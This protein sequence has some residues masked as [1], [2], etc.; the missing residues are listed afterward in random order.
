MNNIRK[1][2]LI[3]LIFVQIILVGILYLKPEWLLNV[4]RFQLE[5]SN[6]ANNNANK[7]C[8][9]DGLFPTY[10]DAIFSGPD[11]MI[12]VFKGS[13]YWLYDSNFELQSNYPK[14]INEVWGS[15]IP[16]DI[17][18]VFEMDSKV[19]FIYADKVWK[20]DYF[21]KETL[22]GWERGILISS[23]WNGLPNNINGVYYYNY[24]ICCFKGDKIYR[25]VLDSQ[26]VSNNTK[27]FK[28]CPT[29]IDACFIYDGDYIEKSRSKLYVFRGDRYYRIN[30]DTQTKE[31]AH[32]DGI[33]ISIIKNPPNIIKTEF[34]FTNKPEIWKVPKTGI[35]R[36]V[37]YGASAGYGGKGSKMCGDF[38]LNKN[39]TLTIY[40]GEKGKTICDDTA[41]YKCKDPFISN[42]KKI[43]NG[44]SGGGS[45]KIIMRNN[46]GDNTPL[47]IAGGGGGWCNLQYSIPE[48][49]HATIPSIIKRE[50]SSAA[51][52]GGS[53]VNVRYL[54]LINEYKR[55]MFSELKIIDVNNNNL[56]DKTRNKSLN[57]IQGLSNTFP[58]GPYFPQNN[59][60]CNDW[61]SS[62]CSGKSV[63]LNDQILSK[64]KCLQLCEKWNNKNNKEGCCYID[65]SG[66]NCSIFDTIE[67]DS[68]NSEEGSGESSRC[69]KYNLE[70]ILDGTSEIAMSTI[71]TRQRRAFIQVDLGKE[72]SLKKIS[73][74]FVENYN[75][76]YV[77]MGLYDS[78]GNEWYNTRIVDAKNE[79]PI[80][81]KQLG[82]RYELE[83]KELNSAPSSKQ[84]IRGGYPDGQS[85]SEV[86]QQTKRTVGGGGGYV[87]GQSNH[88][89]TNIINIANNINPIY[90]GGGSSYINNASMLSNTSKAMANDGD[91]YVSISYV[92]ERKTFDISG[93][94]LCS[95]GM[96][97]DKNIKK[98]HQVVN[99]QF[100]RC[101]L[102]DVCWNKKTG[103][104]YSPN[105]VPITDDLDSVVRYREK[106]VSKGNIFCEDKLGGV[107]KTNLK[108]KNK[109]TNVPNVSIFSNNIRTNKNIILNSNC[110]VLKSGVQYL[111]IP[112]S[113]RANISRMSI[114]LELIFTKF[115]SDG[116][117]EPNMDYVG[118]QIYI[119]N[120][121][122]AVVD[123][124]YQRF[125]L[126]N[127]RP[128]ED[129]IPDNL[130]IFPHG[131]VNPTVANMEEYN[132]DL[133]RLGINTPANNI[134]WNNGW[135]DDKKSVNVGCI[136]GCTLNNFT[137]IFDNRDV[138]NYI[139]I[140]SSRTDFSI[141]LK[142]KWVFQKKQVV[143]K[144]FYL[145]LLIPGNATE[146][147]IYNIA[148]AEYDPNESKIDINNEL[149]LILEEHRRKIMKHNSMNIFSSIP[150]MEESV[151]DETLSQC[152]KPK[153]T[154]THT[155]TYTYI[156]K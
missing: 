3:G 89:N 101:G 26:Q 17:N 42:D 43:I 128:V 47:L 95:D 22:P 8:P 58:V 136:G 99:N 135:K 60:I 70:N 9:T 13:C 25:Y 150:S 122:S 134:K 57:I 44:S 93:T 62:K 152:P 118:K 125:V 34:G 15:N 139:H 56:L 79:K 97:S 41:N 10:I 20:S 90:G 77:S 2:L 45:S 76:S 80:L 54:V 52:V 124:K 67:Q 48:K 35:Y 91:G 75:V 39:E 23:V 69:Q 18:G 153:H 155:H 126:Y 113:A 12:H 119:A 156:T 145:N 138:V 107:F 96:K 24:T 21:T 46:F 83:F 19:Y 141:G 86:M 144:N 111:K 117:V 114:K 53:S 82:N 142:S 147:L 87:S 149:K 116:S 143:P 85:G 84:N 115:R 71:P 55:V 64:D 27:L 49:C 102:P 132:E 154:H 100:K 129:V 30:L 37:A 98:C 36:I 59:Y 127:E 63:V 108:I 16:N 74:K 133:I 130:Q 146:Y 33:P 148:I 29:D 78:Y 106:C 109:C 105:N 123:N 7:L 51:N 11:G 38:N 121:Y 112:I 94:E 151:E 140:N 120:Q 88:S 50:Q 31:N 4:E 28:G 104:C 137:S 72:Y 103:Q 92:D 68:L 32:P 110:G 40:V 131:M 5:N 81:T 65:G 14:P 61:E 6:N 73:I 1:Y 66:K